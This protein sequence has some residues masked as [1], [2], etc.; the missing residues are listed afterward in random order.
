MKY[1]SEIAKMVP[2]FPKL[3]IKC[4]CVVQGVPSSNLLGHV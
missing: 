4:K 3:Y 2:K 1:V